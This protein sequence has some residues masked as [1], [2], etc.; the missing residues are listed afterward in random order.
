MAI[1]QQRLGCSQYHDIINQLN[2]RSIFAIIFEFSV[3]SHK[4]FWPNISQILRKYLIQMSQNTHFL[5]KMQ[6]FLCLVLSCYYFNSDFIYL[7]RTNF[8]LYLF[9]WTKKKFVLR[10][11]LYSRIA[12]FWTFWVYKCQLQRKKNNKKTVESRDIRLMFL[13]RWT[14]GEACHDGKTVVND[15]CWK[16]AEFINIFCAN[17]FSYIYFRKI[18][19]LCIFGVYLFLQMAFKINFSVDLVLWNWLKLS[20]FTKNCTRKS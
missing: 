7:K 4:D 14:E 1:I 10:E 8:R 13:S 2:Q 18:W 11:Y 15:W 5:N 6:A 17:F 16:E 12:N 9:S 19:T 3:M 20:K